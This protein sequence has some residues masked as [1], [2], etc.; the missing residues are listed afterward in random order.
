M[1]EEQIDQDT[2][3]NHGVLHGDELKHDVGFPARGKS[4]ALKFLRLWIDFLRGS[5][6]LLSIGSSIHGKPGHD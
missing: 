5:L 4:P 2:A 3:V 6:C 1:R